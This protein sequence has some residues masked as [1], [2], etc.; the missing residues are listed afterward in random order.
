MPSPFIVAQADS[1][2]L[3]AG[4]T[5]VRTIKVQKP[6]G[7]QAITVQLGYDQAYK[8][9]LSEISNEKIT[10]VHVGEK[11][12]ILFDNKST[13]TVQPFFDSMSAPLPN[14]TVET[15]GRDLTSSEFASTFLITTDQSVLIGFAVGP[16]DTA[17]GADFHGPSVD[18]LGE[19]NP[20]PLL[21]QE[22]VPPIAFTPPQFGPLGTTSGSPPQISPP[23][24]NR[25]TPPTLSPFANVVH[26]ETAGLQTAADPYP[27]NDIAGSNLPAAI[28]AH[29]NGIGAAHGI[30]PHIATKDNGAIGFAASPGDLVTLSGGSQNPAT[31]EYTLATTDGTFSGVSI[32]EGTQIFLYN[33]TGATAGLILGRVG[34]EGGAVDTADPNGTVAFALAVDPSNGTGYIAQYLSL[35]NPVSGS[36]GAALND[37]VSLAPGAVQIQVTYGDGQGGIATSTPIDIG[38]QFGFQDDGPTAGAVTKTITGGGHDTNLMLILDVSGSM[39]DP[40]GLPGLTRL[41]VLKAAVDELLVQYGGIGNVRVQ[42]VE[43]ASNASQVGSDWMTIAQAK[44]AVDALITLDNTNYDAPVATAES[45]FTHAGALTTTGVENVSYFMSDGLPNEPSGSVGMSASEESAWTSFLTAHDIDSFALGMGTGAVPSALDPL[46]FNGPT[47]TNADSIVVTDLSQ[48][49][50]TLIGTINST[51]GNLLTDGVQPGHFGADGGYVKSITVD[52]TV[53]TYDSSLNTITAAGTDHGSF[54]P[55]THK[56]TVIL[57]SGAIFMIDL[58]DG[59]FAYTAPS[60]MPGGFTDVIPF[61]LTDNDG[62]TASNTLTIATTQADHPPA[63]RDDHVITNIA[64]GNGTSIVIPDFALLFND[65]DLDGQTIAVTGISNI[66]SA[67]SANHLAGNVIFVD[68]STDGGSFTYTGSTTSPAANDTGDVSVNRSQTGNTLNGTGVDDILIGRDGSNNVLIAN[69]GNDVLLGGNGTDT[70]N[71]G[72]GNDLLAGNG[73]GDTL[74]GGT[75]ADHFRFN[76]TS[77]GLDHIVDF[78]AADGDLIEVLGLAFGGLPAGTLSASQFVSNAGGNFTDG[79]QRFSFD[80][81]AKTLYYDSDGNGAAV[82]IALAH[83]E[84]GANLDSTNI[85]I[86]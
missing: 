38:Q 51:N 73:G 65:S 53:Y 76:A 78:S 37:Q 25:L 34:I 33:G 39:A 59:S 71:G 24:N 86:V 9:D 1:N 10:F 12:I 46:A 21:G 44:A 20:L 77:D 55:A 64:G 43:F 32:T 26:D 70:L 84:N 7:D 15:A 5:P 54:D 80:T 18:P 57:A 42:M 36:T 56:E 30:D 41:D 83:L 58:D 85:H 72:A 31:V 79:A 11:L 23:A 19:G 48:L 68:N 28:L 62:D 45:I 49:T 47:S 27:A 13:V 81:T 67:N 17:S 66:S 22:E 14:V 40:S 8:L 61:T 6:Q 35:H 4:T 16:D 3:P 60:N 52:G 50:A 69:G 82:K 74:T 63:V 75:G 29:F 2:S